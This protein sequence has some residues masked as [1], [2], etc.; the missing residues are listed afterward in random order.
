MR[1]DSPYCVFAYDLAKRGSAWKI[2]RGS[3]CDF[4][5][6]K[7]NTFLWICVV[8]HAR[9]RLPSLASWSVAFFFAAAARAGERAPSETIERYAFLRVRR[10][11]ASVLGS[12]KSLT[13]A[14]WLFHYLLVTFVVNQKLQAYKKIIDQVCCSLSG[15]LGLGR[16]AYS[17]G[18]GSCRR[19]GKSGA[20]RWARVWFVVG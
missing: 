6:R 9:K 10:A 1:S 7:R 19:Q 11:C 14:R 5:S 15:C 16:I 20:P 13:F 12:R 17:G 8:G 18:G 2:L 4:A 3:L